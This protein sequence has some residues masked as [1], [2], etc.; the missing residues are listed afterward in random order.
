M[1]TPI[2]IP[3]PNIKR[4]DKNSHYLS[5][6][7]PPSPSGSPQTNT[8]LKRVVL[9]GT[10]FK[11]KDTI[12]MLLEDSIEELNKEQIEN[13]VNKSDFT[14]HIGTTV[15]TTHDE[16]KAFRYCQ[17]LVENGLDAKIE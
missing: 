7:Y 6:T 4:I 12:K 5:K 14:K 8:C 17:N 10:P 13:I 9:Y 15:I 11:N 3:L 16:K 1:S 2:Y